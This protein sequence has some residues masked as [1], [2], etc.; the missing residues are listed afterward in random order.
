MLNSFQS[1]GEVAFYIFD[2]P[3]YFYGII[4]AVAVFIGFLTSDY[5]YKKLIQVSVVSP[6]GERAGERGYVCN[7]KNN[8]ILE[9]SPYLIISGIIGARL[10]YVFC[11]W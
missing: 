1:P 9:I 7:K 6:S 8:L 2:M 3:V 11:E 4:M 10:Y 5:L